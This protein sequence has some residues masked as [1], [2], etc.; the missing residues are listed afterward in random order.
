M[1]ASE[2]KPTKLLGARCLALA[3]S[4]TNVRTAVAASGYVDVFYSLL[5]TP[6]EGVADENEDDDDDDLK[7]MM[8]PNYSPSTPTAIGG[9]WLAG[10]HAALALGKLAAVG[11]ITPNNSQ[12]YSLVSKMIELIP[13]KVEGK[14]S[15]KKDSKKES[16][17]G[18]DGKDGK[19]D[20]ENENEK[21]EVGVE[22]LQFA[23]ETLA[24]LS[25]HV[26]VKNCL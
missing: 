26:Y 22:I 14:D 16:K 21:E 8:S 7:S 25:L 20:N 2:H 17:D 24:Y 15:E 6:S 5:A 9:D 1:A 4:D 23:V 11:H 3:S 19:E 10:V 12:R 13:K 18:K